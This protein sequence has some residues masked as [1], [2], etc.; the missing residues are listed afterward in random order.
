VT[1]RVSEV[2]LSG[3]QRALAEEW[4]GSGRP[5]VVPRLAATVMLVRDVPAPVVDRT[6]PGSGE[7]ELPGSAGVEAGVEV[8]VQRRVR[9]MAFAP[10]T[11]VFPGGAVDDAD[12]VLPLD[13]PGLAELAAAMGAS[14]ADAAPRAA[15]AVREVAEECGVLLSV[16]D[17]RARSHWVTTEFE[18][19]RFDTWILAARMP[20]GQVAHTASGE[21]DASEWVRPADLLPRHMVGE[22]AML[23]PTIASLEQ[24]ARF[25]SVD[26]FLADRPH[27]IRIEPRLVESAGGRP[28]LRTHLP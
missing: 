22:V 1:E 15:A 8:F 2:L 11:Y 16:A 26:A 6:R 19:R 18:P 14:A 9:S 24:L 3:A 20:A 4:L 23:P 12:T 21:S 5:A 25:G 13:T 10:A 27:V 7:P 17:L 28:V